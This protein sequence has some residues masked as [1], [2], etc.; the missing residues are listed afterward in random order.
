M[1]KRRGSQINVA[2][3]K[4]LE[5]EVAE[6]IVKNENGTSKY[7]LVDRCRVY[8]RFLKL[9]QLKLKVDDPQWGSKFNGGDD[10]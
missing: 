8:D 9:E 3:E 7:S 6:I 10:E 1:S 5:A 2:L 4:A